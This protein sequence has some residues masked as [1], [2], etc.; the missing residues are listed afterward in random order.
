MIYWTALSTLKRI[1]R[2]TIESTQMKGR[3]NYEKKIFMVKFR[4]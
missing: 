4:S 2:V 3:A 1:L